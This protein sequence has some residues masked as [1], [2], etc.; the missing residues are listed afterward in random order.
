MQSES[1]VSSTSVRIYTGSVCRRGS[2]RVAIAGLFA[3]LLLVGCSDS[4]KNKAEPEKPPEVVIT[5]PTVRDVTEY[6]EFSGRTES[7]LSVDVRARVTGYL[8]KLYFKDGTDVSQGDVLFQIDPRT[9]KAELDKAVAQFEQQKAHLK[10]LSNEFERGKILHKR[11]VITQ[12]EADRVIYDKAETEASLA[13]SNA[14]RESAALNVAFTR[15]TAPLSG[16]VSRRSVDPGNLVKADDTVLTTIVA[17]DPLYA[18][19][20]VDERTLLRLRRLEAD[21]KIKTTS[22]SDLCVQIGLADEDGFSLTGAIDFADNRVDPNTGTLR[23]RAV[24]ANPKRVLAPGLFVRLRLPIGKPHS[25]LLVPEE[26]IGSDQGQK[27][28]FVVNENNET[29]YRRVKVG[30]LENEL[31]VIESGI[32]PQEWVVVTGLQRIRAGTKVAPSPRAAHEGAAAAKTAKVDPVPV[33]T[34]ESTERTSRRTVQAN[35]KR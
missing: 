15:V 9:Y 33:P 28:V 31:R 35:I 11:G 17:L 25:A 20:D 12:E 6:E 21:G 23:L 34:S 14:A 10:R 8:D 2:R 24:V 29:V 4:G 26:S 1:E 7:S 32:S 18:Y 5:T 27:Y 30:K 19:F 13:A 3:V 22:G 16:R